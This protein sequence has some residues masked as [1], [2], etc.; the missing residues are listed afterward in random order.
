MRLDQIGLLVRFGFLLRLPQF[1]DQAHGFALQAAIEAAPGARVNN[2]SELFGGEVEES[3]GVERVG[4][5][6]LQGGGKKEDILVEIDASVGE[7]AE[8]SLLFQFCGRKRYALVFSAWFFA[9]A[10]FFMG[11]CCFTCHCER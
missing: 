1:F 4:L 2:I 9:L 6:I 7:F 3:G 10:A 5:A 11:L 8:G